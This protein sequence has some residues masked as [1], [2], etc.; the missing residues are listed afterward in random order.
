V[1]GYNHSLRGDQER[2]IEAE[3]LDAARDLP[4]LFMAM[5]GTNIGDNS[6]KRG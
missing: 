4:N 2:D 5:E 3:C 6:C 1:P